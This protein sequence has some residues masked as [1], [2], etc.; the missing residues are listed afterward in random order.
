MIFVDIAQLVQLHKVLQELCKLRHIGKL[1]LIGEQFVP[2]IILAFHHHAQ[3]I[4]G[5]HL[6]GP[7]ILVRHVHRHHACV[8]NLLTEIEELLVGGGLG[9]DDANL[10]QHALVV[11]SCREE[12]CRGERHAVDVPIALVAQQVRVAQALHPGLVIQHHTVFGGVKGLHHLRDV[13]AP[14]LR[15]FT[16]SQLQ[17]HHL[18]GGVGNHLHIHLDAGLGFKIGYDLVGKN[19]VKMI[20]ETR[21]SGHES[22]GNTFGGSI[23]SFGA[24]RS[25]IT[26]R[27]SLGSRFLYGRVTAPCQQAGNQN[28]YK[29]CSNTSFL[30][31]KS[32]LLSGTQNLITAASDTQYVFFFHARSLSIRNFSRGVWRGDKEMGG[33]VKGNL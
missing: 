29:H 19:A 20:D 8:L 26:G 4:G 31:D 30:H 6:G 5:K 28:Q 23:A 11:V 14:Q 15:R 9:I 12:L 25:G 2:H 17:L 21:L 1:L 24:R 7:G 27:G 13:L 22:D 18:V 10:L 33:A 3:P 32:S 16:G